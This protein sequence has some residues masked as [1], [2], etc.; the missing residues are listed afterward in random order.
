MK[1]RLTLALKKYP[2]EH[3]FRYICEAKENEDVQ[4]IKESVCMLFEKKYGTPIK[5]VK[6]DQIK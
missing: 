5:C 6:I 4:G 3:K 2:A 1:Y